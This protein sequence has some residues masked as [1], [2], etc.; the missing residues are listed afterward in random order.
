MGP[1]RDVRGGAAGW[2]GGR[3][4]LGR[5]GG[6]ARPSANLPAPR[7]RGGTARP[8]ASVGPLTRLSVTRPL[9]SEVVL[10]DADMRAART[11]SW[12]H[13]EEC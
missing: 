10:F 6:T 13:Q 11:P 9:R 1:D 4:G 7:G 3:W 12:A 5:P 8:W 2:T